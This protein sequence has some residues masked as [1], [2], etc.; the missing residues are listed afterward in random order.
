MGE[1]MKRCVRREEE[2][3]RK[4]LRQEKRK[5]SEPSHC[6]H[7]CTQ[8]RFAFGVG[9]LFTF[10][11][12]LFPPHTRFWFSMAV[13]DP[14]LSLE[15][16]LR[17][18]IVLALFAHTFWLGWCLPPSHPLHYTYVQNFPPFFSRFL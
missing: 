12:V 14:T 18:A 8:S 3:G 16:V 11:T 9:L 15:G 1:C 6:M 4:E 5:E 17:R 10:D 7:A 13:R 2:D